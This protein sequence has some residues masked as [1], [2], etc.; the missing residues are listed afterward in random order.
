[1]D[2]HRIVFDNREDTARS[3][4]LGQI[5]AIGFNM[6]TNS[7]RGCLGKRYHWS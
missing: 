6:K 5:V 2:K 7:R 1:M 4:D 3:K